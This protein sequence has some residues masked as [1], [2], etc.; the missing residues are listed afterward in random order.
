VNLLLST[1]FCSVA[2]AISGAVAEGQ[3]VVSN[4][5]FTN[6]YVYQPT[7]PG[8][9]WDQH[10]LKLRPTDGAKFSRA[11]ID[12]FTDTMM[13][14]GSPSYFDVLHQYWG[15]NPPQFFGSGIATAACVNAAI[16]DGS[17]VNGNLLIQWDTIRSLANCHANGLDPSPQVSII[18]SPDIKIGKI[19]NPPVG[20]TGDMCTTTSTKGWHAWG[21]NMPNFIALPTDPN[22]ATTFNDLT[23]TFSHEIVE[24]LT[25]PGGFG[26]G[27]VLDDPTSV[28][29]N[30]IGDK[31]QGHRTTWSGYTVTQYW[32]KNSNACEPR[33]FPASQ[34]NI[35]RD[36]L[37]VSDI[38]LIRFTGDR[39]DLTEKLAP[40][41]VGRQ[42]KSLRMIISTGNDDL[43]GNGDNCDVTINLADG[44]AIS[45][46]NVNHGQGW[47]NWSIH[48]F[49]V[50]L[51]TGGVNGGDIT[52]I[53][54]HT[55][56]GGFDFTKSPDNWNVQRV[57]LKAMVESARIPRPRP[58]LKSTVTVTISR[59]GSRIA[60]GPRVPGIP[61]TSA[62]YAMIKINGSEFERS[63]LSQ[64][65]LLDLGT[66][67]IQIEVW[68][69][70]PD[71]KGPGNS[72]DPNNP[73][74]RGVHNAK[75]TLQTLNIDYNLKTHTFTARGETGP[76]LPGKAGVEL[77]FPGDSAHPGVA[78]T[79]TDQPNSN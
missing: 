24:T 43:R 75:A 18:L 42:A 51:P 68:Q 57:Q 2:F 29:E 39:H 30:E 36:W 35:E 41:D 9:T 77:A 23:S 5:K 64:S 50:P 28:G 15:I 11:S 26:S 12:A 71:Y 33:V 53:K 55:V 66:V 58:L 21:L 44:R 40:V 37:N 46:P 3:Q 7:F 32:S 72:K 1:L 34:T 60:T 27:G 13:S 17:K 48:S 61:A 78:F 52:E 22:C 8:E 49:N 62:A 20:T 69:D 76:A 70:L 45:L 73:G 31:C 10:I 74:G 79:I 4:G 14:P 19:P 65:M 67:P 6:V 47:D 59:V 54:L 25:D 63:P 38:P 16:R 56:R